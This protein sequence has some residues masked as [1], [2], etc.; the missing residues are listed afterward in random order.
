MALALNII[1]LFLEGIGL[2]ISFRARKWGNFVF[3]T[4]LSNMLCALS[5]LLFV[6]FSPAAWVTAVRYLAACGLVMTFLVTICVLIPMGGDPKDLLLAGNG[7]YHH[8]LCPILCVLSYVLFEP[9]AGRNMVIPS[10][11]LTLLYGLI[12]LYLNYIGK[13]DS[14]YPFVCVRERSAGA[15]VLWMTVLVMV[16]GAM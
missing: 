10:M 2:S 15:T 3:Y 16:I 1:L 14:P 4:Q 6:L 12:M 7:L 9:H 13:V 5:S 11:A 8:V